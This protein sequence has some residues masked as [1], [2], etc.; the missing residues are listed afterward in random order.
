MKND[1]EHTKLANTYQE[2]PWNAEAKLIELLE[3]PVT[4]YSLLYA[5][6]HSNDLPIIDPIKYR[7][8]IDGLVDSSQSLSL[9]QI[10]ALPAKTFDVA[11]QCAGLRRDEM[12]DRLGQ[13]EGVAWSSAAISNCTYTG[14]LLSSVIAELQL[15]VADEAKH[16]H[17][18][19]HSVACS[20]AAIYGGSI[21]AN[22]IDSNDV[23]L[24]YM[25]N[26]SP[27]PASH[28]GP[29][30]LVTPGIYGARS[31]KWIDTISFCKDEIEN[32]YQAHDY[33][34]LPPHIKD[35]SQADDD[36]WNSLPAMI[37]V[38]PNSV[39]TKCEGGYKGY[40]VSSCR[41]DRV[42]VSFDGATTWYPAT[43]TYQSG[44]WSWTL[45][46]IEG[47]AM[48]AD[49]PVYSRATDIKGN[50]QP[51]TVSWNLRGVGNNEYGTS[52]A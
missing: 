33:K 6:N 47:R 46:T 22:Y 15:N 27:M 32:F 7:L 23:L 24:A 13:T 29:I 18:K 14:V 9:D 51:A 28:G 44:D 39:I 42:D 34:V 49:V 43:I 16:V 21:P 12:N 48:D 5:R 3:H 50:V 4:P 1:S 8:V 26:G 20:D 17:F 31:V 38:A 2:S 45:F 41:I 25:L 30:R 52:A 35:Q 40:A 10:K 37:E 36:L 11:M 19:C